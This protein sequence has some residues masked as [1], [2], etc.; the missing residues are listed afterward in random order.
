MEDM[1]VFAQN[2]QEDMLQYM[3]EVKRLTKDAARE[4]KDEIQGDFRSWVKS[5]DRG[6]QHEMPNIERE[7]KQQL[8]GYLKER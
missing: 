2:L 4:V 5:W 3:K 6:F 8:S 7:L 1:E